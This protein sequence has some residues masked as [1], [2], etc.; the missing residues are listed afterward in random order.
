MNPA[1]APTAA[2]AAAPIPRCPNGPAGRPD[3]RPGGSP[4]GGATRHGAN[5]PGRDVL[6]RQLLALGNVLLGL[7]LANPGQMRIR[8]QHR[9]APGAPREGKP[10]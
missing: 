10:E 1:I 2:P 7:A 6:V 9:R 8:V 3:G 4:H 5:A